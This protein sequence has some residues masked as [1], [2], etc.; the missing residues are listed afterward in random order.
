MISRFAKHVLPSLVFLL[1]PLFLHAQTEDTF[2]VRQ[3]VGT[4]TVPPTTPAFITAVP[5]AS[6]QINVA[7]GTSTDDQLFGGY[8]LLRDAVHIATTSLL[9]YSDTGLTPGTTYTYTVEAY[10]WLN[11]ISTSSSPV[12]TTTYEV[13][14]LEATTTVSNIGGNITPRLV[15]FSV[16]PTAESAAFN[17]STNIYTRYI[18]RWGVTGSYELG[19][20]QSDAYKRDHLTYVEGLK[21]ETEYQYELIGYNQRGDLYPLEKGSFVTRA[22]PDVIAPANVSNLQLVSES[23]TVFVSWKNPPDVD[24]AKVRVVRNHLFYPQS[25]T[26]GFIVYEGSAQSLLDPGVLSGY[27]RQYYT[28]FTYDR[29]GNV[30]SGAIGLAQKGSS[31][32]TTSNPTEENAVGDTG[33]SSSSA[34]AQAGERITFEDVTFMQDGL[35]LSH[36]EQ[37]VVVRD[38][39]P[40]TITLAADLLPRHLKTVTVTLRNGEGIDQSYILRANKSRSAY[41]ARITQ[42]AE[43]TYGATFSIYDFNLQTET[44]FTGEVISARYANGLD[45]NPPV[46]FGGSVSERFMLYGIFPV[47]VLFMFILWWYFF[48]LR[49]TREDN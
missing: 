35:I 34:D 41:E 45:L 39:M 13:V 29:L 14:I 15:E 27:D 11:N 6:T 37:N 1:F 30:S 4:D 47:L 38:D 9:S 21:P 36:T 49:R 32:P 18:L 44:V 8:R 48:V 12:S 25:P 16:D 3:Q 2:R 33:S 20:V 17:W 22:L 5:I 43:G 24:F 26:D 19:F 46:V 40:I 28:V 31:R 23:T 10:D 7:W 42:L